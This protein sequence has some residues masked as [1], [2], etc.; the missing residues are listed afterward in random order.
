[1][2]LDSK[3]EDVMAPVE[4][5][6]GNRAWW[7]ENPMAYAWRDSIDA[8]RY[9]EPWFREVDRRFLHGSRLYA[10]KDQPFDRI[11]P[12]PALR[13]RRVLEIGC[14]MGFHTQT[15]A[16]AGATVTAVDLTSTAI[17]ATSAR[18]KHAG[19]EARLLQCDAEALPFDDEEFDYVWSWGVIHH[20]SRTA[21]IVR[22]I[23]RVLRPDCSCGVMVYNREGMPARLA[24]WKDHLLK[25]GFLHGSYEETL[26]R[27]T[28]GFSARFYVKDQF[29]DLFRAF[30]KDVECRICGQDADV[31]PLPGWARRPLLGF[32]TRRYQEVAQSQRGAFLFLMASGRD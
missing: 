8:P 11:L 15:M 24:Y 29:E 23:A 4:V 10:T 5:Q 28:D 17:D 25:G 31:I 20:S 1:M 22:E 32:T 21:R 26:F 27:S 13:G 30:F 18:L 7:Q 16:A 3:R 2:N 6:S 19:L 9:S 12:L 14:G